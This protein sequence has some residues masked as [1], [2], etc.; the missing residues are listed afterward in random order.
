MPENN[1]SR[2]SSTTQKTTPQ[3]SKA[4]AGKGS[5]QTDPDAASSA[6]ANSTL[7]TRD[8]IKYQTERLTAR[9]STRAGRV[10]LAD[11]PGDSSSPEASA[12][13]DS[14]SSDDEQSPPP[15]VRVPPA[16]QGIGREQALSTNSQRKA[17]AYIKL[18]KLTEEN[19]TQWERQVKDMCF[20]CGWMPYFYKAIPHELEADGLV[21]IDA[22]AAAR[23]GLEDRSL[24][25][26]KLTY[27]FDDELN[28][29]EIISKRYGDVVKLLRYVRKMFYKDSLYAIATLTEQLLA[30]SLNDYKDLQA[31]IAGFD[32]IMRQLLCAGKRTMDG[33]KCFYLLRGLT[34]DYDA[35]KAQISLHNIANKQALYT[36]K[37][38]LALLREWS[39]ARGPPGAAKR[40]QVTDQA[41]SAHAVTSSSTQLCRN[42]AKG[43][44]CA[45]SPCRYSHDAATANAQASGRQSGGVNQ[46]VR[47]Q[48]QRQLANANTRKSD[49]CKWCQKSGHT[50]ADCRMLEAE[51][52]TR[53]KNAQPTRDEGKSEE[54]QVAVRTRRRAPNT[55]REQL[56]APT[57]RD[58]D[59]WQSTQDSDSDE[60]TPD[61]YT[62]MARE[63]DMDDVKS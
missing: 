50:V 58:D 17:S 4:K 14:G 20:A 55:Q 57:Q 25:W 33:D 61:F 56:P 6:N 40:L 62:F 32:A 12:H 43:K 26:Q 15:R 10:S 19:Y 34:P 38:T 7:L 45:Y 48:S 30:L 24:L 37:Q 53:Q 47:V 51:I 18:M 49:T 42:F 22:S 23:L 31:Y 27:S 28:L 39:A 60:V 1:K 16:R 59:Q 9:S 29:S 11:D 41:F 46:P 13:G 8:E 2:S 63:I 35:L 54:V 36:Y 5:A 21:T 52:R 44:T 3:A